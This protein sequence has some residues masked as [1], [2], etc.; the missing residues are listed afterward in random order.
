MA[1][2]AQPAAPALTAARIA[3]RCRE[4]QDSTQI[5][6]LFEI[7][8]VISSFSSDFLLD[9]L[10]AE[11]IAVGTKASYRRMQNNFRAWLMTN[12]RE[13]VSA[14]GSEILLPITNTAAVL[15]YLTTKSFKNGNPEQGQNTHGTIGN[16]ISAI[17]NLYRQKNM[18]VDDALA[19]E[20]SR[21]S[22]GLNFS[23]IWFVYLGLAFNSFCKL[24]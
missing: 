4:I 16:E 17:K 3:E 7:R 15:N 13:M 6:F 10:F 11:E 1:A 23:F 21:F 9:R 20:I 12:H 18:V 5:I 19:S 2:V 8:H 14:D 24:F 22:K